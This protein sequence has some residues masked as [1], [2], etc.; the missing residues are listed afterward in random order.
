MRGCEGVRTRREV[1]EAVA[2]A[3]GADILTSEGAKVRRGREMSIQ[4]SRRGWQVLT[5][6]NGEDQRRRSRGR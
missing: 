4:T 2:V 3:V 5:L 6:V 1:E